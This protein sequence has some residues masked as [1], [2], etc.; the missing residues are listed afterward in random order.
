MD[1]NKHAVKSIF[2]KPAFRIGIVVL[3]VH[4]V[5]WY[6][7]NATNSGANNKNAAAK[8][9]ENHEKIRAALNENK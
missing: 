6:G 4:A 8:V 7:W 1:N 9:N 3:V 5:C 2:H